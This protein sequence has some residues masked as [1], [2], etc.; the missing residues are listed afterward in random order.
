MTI[1]SALY[2]PFLFLLSFQQTNEWKAPKEADALKNPV[3]DN[4]AATAEGKKLYTMYC[5]TCH[6]DK[7]KGDGPAGI[8]LTPKP[9]NFS[10]QKVQAQTDGA[11]FWKMTNGR[12]PMAPYKDILKE[13][14]RW[15][16]VNYIRELGKTATPVKKK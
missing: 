12:P 5:A 1:V 4:A 3:K 11:I 9:G 10:T 13:E 14:Q 15:Q 7:G 2:I 16:L 6:G 8:A